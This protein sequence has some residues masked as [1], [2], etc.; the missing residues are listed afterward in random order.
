[1]SVS[2]RDERGGE[3]GGG[4]GRDWQGGQAWRLI[5]GVEKA[6]SGRAS[7]LPGVRGLGRGGVERGGEAG[8]RRRGRMRGPAPDVAG[9]AGGEAVAA[10]T[11]A[12]PS[13]AG[14]SGE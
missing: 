10:A 7:R 11:P 14:Q 8:P 4:Q 3:G 12:P 2:K 5:A 9:E 6:R 13:N 1:M